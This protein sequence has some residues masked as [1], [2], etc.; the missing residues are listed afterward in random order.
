MFEGNKT[1][2]GKNRQITSNEG[3]TNLETQKQT[4]RIEMHQ[5]QNKNHDFWNPS[6]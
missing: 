5:S 6:R 2:I 3:T 4:K 1:I